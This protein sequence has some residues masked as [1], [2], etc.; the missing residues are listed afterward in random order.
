MSSTGNSGWSL[1]KDGILWKSIVAD[2]L[3]TSERAI[4]FAKQL[5]AAVGPVNFLQGLL[6]DRVAANCLRQQALAE[7][8][9]TTVPDLMFVSPDHRAPFGIADSL[10]SPSFRNLLRYESLL[11]QAFHRDLILLQALRKADSATSARM[12]TGAPALNPNTQ[13]QLEHLIKGES[14]RNVG[15][16][17]AQTLASKP[18]THR[19]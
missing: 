14:G 8:Q 1:S 16:Q 17:T 9:R 18:I 7:V 6:L 11:N 3:I 12:D 4:R 2:D 19:R 10:G 5:E 15:N 13:P